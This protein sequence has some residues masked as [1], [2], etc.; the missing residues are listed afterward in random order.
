MGSARNKD[1]LEGFLINMFNDKNIL[2]LK[3]D[4]LRSLLASF[5]VNMRLNKVWDN[6]NKIGSKSP[7]HELTNLLVEKLSIML[8]ELFITTSM[9]Y[10]SPFSETACAKIEN[11]NIKDVILFPLYPHYSTTTTKSSVE[12][13]IG[14][15]NGKFNIT[16]I[17]PFYKNE[18][19]NKAICDEIIKV[20]SK[21][22][23]FHLIFSAY[24]LP[25][26]N[27]NN[28]D[29][30]QKEIEDHVELLKEKLSHYAT[31]IKSINLAYQSKV[32]HLKWL[33]P[34]LEDMLKKFKNKKV[35]IYPISFIIDNSET[36]FELDVEYRDI[37]D[38]LRIKEYKVCA[39]VNSTDTFVQ[40]VKGI[41]SKQLI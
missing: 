32:A 31:S 25:L 33:S 14:N 30:Y 20:Q 10:T 19:Y 24:G 23:D 37:A 35:I 1:E 11:E 39:C 21:Y 26:K 17:E 15:A 6:Y 4:T 34:S 38:K 7:L 2:T 5:I 28:G 12:D 3:N 40:S 18:M 41:I 9:R 22:N 36:K 13:F 29:Q 8:P 16:T 27:V